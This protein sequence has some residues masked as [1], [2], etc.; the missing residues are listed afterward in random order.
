MSTRSETHVYRAPT[1]RIGFLPAALFEHVE[2]TRAAAIDHRT[3][4]LDPLNPESATG[5]RAR[6]P[7]GKGL[8]MYIPVKVRPQYKNLDMGVGVRESRTGVVVEGMQ[9]TTS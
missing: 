8:H 3:A 5:I 4:W 9:A 7:V 6:T 1:A 2:H